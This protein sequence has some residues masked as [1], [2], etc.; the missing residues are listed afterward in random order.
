MLLGWNVN[1]ENALRLTFLESGEVEGVHIL[2]LL[3]PREITHLP[4]EII[5]ART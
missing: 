3:C 2:I 5:Y 4:K 1:R